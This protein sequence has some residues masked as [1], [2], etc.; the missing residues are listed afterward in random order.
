V[1]DR[2]V[3]NLWERPLNEVM[4]Q[5]DFVAQRPENLERYREGDLLGFLLKLDEEQAEL[6]S[7]RLNGPAIIKG[8]PG[9]G[10]ST[11]ALYRVKSLL[12]RA[13]AAG[14]S[15]PHIHFTTYTN[16]LTRFSEQLLK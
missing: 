3:D 13:E 14:Q 8:G 12:D 1:L 4:Q 15:D 16:A 11:V 9:T 10:G 2:M 6:A 7:W 5:P